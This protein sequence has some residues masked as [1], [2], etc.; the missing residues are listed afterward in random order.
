MENEQVVFTDVANGTAAD[1]SL[2][3][4]ESSEMIH[5]RLLTEGSHGE[6]AILHLGKLTQD[7]GCTRI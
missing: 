6:V 2:K 7:H 3:M 1:H 4:F 5:P